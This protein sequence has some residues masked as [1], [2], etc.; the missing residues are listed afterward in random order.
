MTF[1]ILNIYQLLQMSP[2]QAA[3]KKCDERTLK[4][5]LLIFH[6]QEICNWHLSGRSWERFVTE[7]IEKLVTDISVTGS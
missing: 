4:N 1:R 7:N 3:T 6:G 2:R 5:Q